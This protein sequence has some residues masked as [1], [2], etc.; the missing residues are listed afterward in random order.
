MRASVLA[1]VLA[2]AAAVV[3]MVYPAVRQWWDADRCVDGG[4]RWDYQT[5]NCIA[6]GR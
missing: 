4:G 2:L 1:L 6:L 5:E 3:V